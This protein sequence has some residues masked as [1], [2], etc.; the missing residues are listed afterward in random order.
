MARSHSSIFSYA[1]ALWFTCHWTAPPVRL[2]SFLP[3][4]AFSSRGLP[5]F[6]LRFRKTDNLYSPWGF[7]EAIR[8]SYSW[9]SGASSPPRALPLPDILLPLCTFIVARF[10]IFVNSFC[11][12]FPKANIFQQLF[13]CIRYENL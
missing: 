7:G 9:I 8:E 11:E 4:L 6:S 13:L 2:Y 10:F 5:D 1:L 3:N 12:L